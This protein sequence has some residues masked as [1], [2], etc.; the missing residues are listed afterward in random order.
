MRSLCSHPSRTGGSRWEP[1]DKLRC[2]L[3]PLVFAEACTSQRKAGALG[4]FLLFPPIA[5]HASQVTSRKVP[6][7]VLLMAFLCAPPLLFKGR[8]RKAGKG[9]CYLGRE[10]LLLCVSFLPGLPRVFS[11]HTSRGPALG[12]G[13]RSSVAELSQAPRHLFLRGVPL[14]V[15]LSLVLGISFSPLERNPSQMFLS[16]TSLELSVLNT[17]GRACYRGH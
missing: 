15:K 16:I 2:C 13:T 6:A 3:M 12:T 14:L 4:S 10:Q 5:D 17:E 11:G 1:A 8:R 9:R 7:A